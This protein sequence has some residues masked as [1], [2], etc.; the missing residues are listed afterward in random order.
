MTAKQVKTITE[1]PVA[2]I[3][4]EQRLRPVSDAGVE[5]I[6][7]SV[8][9]LGII[10]DPVHVRKVPH[11]GNKLIL[12]AGG[13]R[14]EAAKRMGWDMIPASVW[15]CNDTWARLL[16]VDD[17]LAGAELTA[18][19][20]AVFL[21]ERKR[22]YEE[23]HPETKRGLAGAKARWDDATEL[24]SFASATAEKFGLSERQVRKIASA[25]AKLDPQECQQLRLAPRPVSLADLQTIG[26]IGDTVER[27]EVVEAL[28]TGRAKSAAKARKA[29]QTRD[30]IAVQVD[31]A[32]AEY[33]ELF[34]L[35]SRASKKVR[36]RFVEDNRKAL[37]RLFEQVD[38]GAE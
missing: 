1:L 33:N 18:L 7:A 15:T 8:A 19:D 9:E 28:A 11:R 25:G 12:M 37:N 24:S 16:E 23:L 4:V 21:A 38:G 31:P 10:K 26:K 34:K 13:H 32:E 6:M 30:Q 27:Y 35:W 36:L 17:N 3:V 20:N 22:L 29:Y 5:A 2:D 14:L